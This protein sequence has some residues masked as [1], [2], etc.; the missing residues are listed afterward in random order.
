MLVVIIRKPEND[1]RVE[2]HQKSSVFVCVSSLLL[3]LR[4]PTVK[5]LFSAALLLKNEFRE[6]QRK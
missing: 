3:A 6:S 1:A 4:K 5:V 2:Y